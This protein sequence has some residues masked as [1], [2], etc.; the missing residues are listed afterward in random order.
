MPE[1]F[2]VEAPMWTASLGGTGWRVAAALE[3]K[4]K[5]LTFGLLYAEAMAFSAKAREGGTTAE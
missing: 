5:R 4:T 2:Q 1:S 3:V